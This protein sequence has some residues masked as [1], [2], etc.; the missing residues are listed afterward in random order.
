LVVSAALML[1][2]LGL[3]TDLHEASGTA[4]FWIK[5][6][7]SAGLGLAGLWA[8]EQLSHPGHVGRGPLM[9][10]IGLL[11]AVAAASVVDYALAPAE[12]RRAMLLGSSALA[13]PLY[14]IALSAPLLVVGLM[15][16][17]RLVPTNLTLAGVAA[18]LMAGALGAWVYSFH[19]T[20]GCRALWYTLGVAAIVALGALLVRTRLR[21]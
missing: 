7:R 13:C 2:W 3:R 21:W 1:A 11:F 5:S 10:A 4:I 9:L 19:C 15:L 18:G 20:G 16:M 14:I 8:T 12:A 17:R 6:G